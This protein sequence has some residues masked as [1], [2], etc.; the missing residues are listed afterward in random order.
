MDTLVCRP[1]GTH[2][3]VLYTYVFARCVELMLCQ[4]LVPADGKPY[5]TF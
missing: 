4:M 1:I 3:I 5:M 2:K